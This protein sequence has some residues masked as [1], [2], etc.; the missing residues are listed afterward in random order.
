MQTSRFIRA[1]VEIQGDA[2]GAVFAK[3]LGISKQFWSNLR[4]GQRPLP[5][6]LARRWI[7]IWPMLTADFVADTVAEVLPVET[8]PEP[9]RVA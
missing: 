2:T 7:G 6:A 5:K 3:R 8:K 9:D 1:L 4:T